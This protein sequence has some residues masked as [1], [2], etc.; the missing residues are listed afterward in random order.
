MLYTIIAGML[1][2]VPALD[3]LNET[4]R[5]LYFHV[6]MWFTM[7]L[8]L[9]ISVVNS[10]MFLRGAKHYRDVVAAESAKTGILFAMM[11][12]FTGML[13]AQ[14]T[15]GK[16]W[17]NDPKLNGVAASMLVYSAYFLL[18]NSV[19]DDEKRARYTAVYNVFAYVMMML[20]IMIL[21]RLTASLHPGKW[22]QSGILNL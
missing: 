19:D 8:L 10:I 14:F 16:F 9:T 1:F 11:G 5:N 6:T 3:I 13:W 21:P 2:P 17:T 7:I 4:I 22:R 12:L 18:R 15:W 20:F